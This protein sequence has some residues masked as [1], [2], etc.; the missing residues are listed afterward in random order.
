MKMT[1]ITNI[2]KKAG[3]KAGKMN[4]IQLVRAI[5]KAEGNEE[6]FSTH[7]VNACGQVTCSW[8]EDCK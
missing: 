1:D 3:V 5:Q 2:A 4:K 7:Q 8:R 6:C